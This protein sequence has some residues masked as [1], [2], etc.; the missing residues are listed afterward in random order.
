MIYTARVVLAMTDWVY[1]SNNKINPHY[2]GTEHFL[3]AQG[4]VGAQVVY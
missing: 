4:G 3:K 2:V 1:N